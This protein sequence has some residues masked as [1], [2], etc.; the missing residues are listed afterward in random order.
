MSEVRPIDANW[1]KNWVK[2][3]CNPYGNPTIGSDDGRRFMEQI[4]KMPTLEPEVRHGRWENG[5]CTNCKHNL[6]E[7]CSGED[8]ELSM[9]AEFDADFCPFCGVRM[10]GGVENG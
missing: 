2:K 1:L 7:L 8:Y 3:E 6:L 10:D 5:K 9:Y 4:D